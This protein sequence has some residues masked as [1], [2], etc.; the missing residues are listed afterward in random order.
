MSEEMKARGAAILQ[1]VA[2]I[3][4]KNAERERLLL[5]LEQVAALMLQGIDPNEIKGWVYDPMKDKTRHQH[6]L[7]KRPTVYNVL[8]MKD[9][10]VVPLNPPVKMLPKRDET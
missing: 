6:E 3:R 9:G 7:Y 1:A 4:A 10:S 8:H 2:A 5:E